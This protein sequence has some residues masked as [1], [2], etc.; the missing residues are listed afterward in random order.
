MDTSDGLFEPPADRLGRRLHAAVFDPLPTSVGRACDTP[1][2]AAAL[3]PLL[4]R[5]WR[6]AQLSARIGA[7]PD[8]GGDPVP[9]VLAFLELLLERSSPQQEHRHQQRER[10]RERAAQAARAPVPATDA[11]RQHWVAQARRALGMM[12]RPRPLLSPATA[13]GCACCPG[14]GTF[15]VTRQVRLCESCVQLLSS[16][17]ARLAVS[18]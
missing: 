9:A 8:S 7:L 11:Q 3:R 10:E 13:R 14:Q 2:V 16:G 1:Q 12:D 6:P 5:G 15:F 17:Q 18:A 4:A